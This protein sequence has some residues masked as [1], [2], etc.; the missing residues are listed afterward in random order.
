MSLLKKLI[1]SVISS[2]VRQEVQKQT[3]SEPWNQSSRRREP[4]EQS[5]PKPRSASSSAP[6]GE[7][8]GP[9]MPSEPN[10][11]NSG[12]T[13][14]RYFQKIFCEN[15]PSYQLERD[16]RPYGRDTTVFTFW[17]GNC[18]ALVVEIKS[19]KDASHRLRSECAGAG[20]PYLCFYHNHYGWWNTK[21]YVI[22]RVSAAL[23]S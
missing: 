17:S 18:K 3:G 19:E 6:S 5:A 1:R 12:L 14:S 4:W 16:D 15:Y 13:Y 11:F 23:R 2:E 21:S 9:D 8:W 22:K 10:Q 20:V 7:S